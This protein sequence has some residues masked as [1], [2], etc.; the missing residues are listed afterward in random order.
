MVTG[1]FDDSGRERVIP[2]LVW[3]V[4]RLARRHEVIVY[5]LRYLESPRR[6]QLRGATIQDLGR[7]NG[8]RAQYA[9]V[10]AAIRRDGP[11]D[12]L[13]GYWAMPAGL[14]AA[15]AGRRLGIPAI[16]TCDSGEFVSIPSVPYGLQ[17]RWRHR[18]GVR[19]ATRLARAVTVC[20]NYQR[21]LAEQLGVRARVIP[22][23]V[24]TTRHT[25]GHRR[26]AGPPYRLLHVASINPVKDHPT[27]LQAV[28]QLRDAG[29]PLH[30][31]IAGEDTLAGAIQ[32]LAHTLRLDDCVTFHGFQSTDS[33]PAFYQA[34]DLFVL[35][36][37]HEA[38]GVVLLEAAASGVPVVGSAVGYLADWSPHA[39]T[40]V[41]PGNASGLADA[42]QQLLS[43]PQRRERQ[44]RAAADF[45]RAHDADWTAGAF[46]AL[47]HELTGRPSQPL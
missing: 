6:Y 46:D 18:T 17:A 33:L 11:V 3:L 34:A 15:L 21:T 42:I 13:H 43:D 44:A 28:R 16:V 32:Q 14:V 4:E 1:G 47:Y 40:S 35:P 10:V 20:S 24:D 36:S 12:V 5:V 23:G 41:Q 19:I 9:A 27:L 31:D 7:P 38:A 8:L 25:P 37:R 29:I 45:A 30:L 39:A 22:I 2:S 26:T